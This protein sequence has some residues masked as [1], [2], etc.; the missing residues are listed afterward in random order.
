MAAAASAG[1]LRADFDHDLA[2]WRN[3]TGAK[4][5]EGRLEL[6]DN[7]TLRATAGADWSD[8][9]FEVDLPDA[10]A[11]CGWRRCRPCSWSAGNEAIGE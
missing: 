7:Q 11:V 6:H 9:T 5:G 4:L 10:G 2:A 1:D 3:T 8:Y